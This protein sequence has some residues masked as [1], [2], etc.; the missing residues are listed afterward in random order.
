MSFKFE[1]CLCVKTLKERPFINGPLMN[2]RRRVLKI[3]NHINCNQYFFRCPFF[4]CLARRW[5]SENS[6][7]SLAQDEGDVTHIAINNEPVNKISFIFV[8]HCRFLTPRL[9]TETRAVFGS[10]TKSLFFDRQ[11]SFRLFD[12]S[13]KKNYARFLFFGMSAF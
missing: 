13:P 2:Y 7:V 5:N 6:N 10:V 1:L 3:V 9:F 8:Q 11:P 12:F 4:N